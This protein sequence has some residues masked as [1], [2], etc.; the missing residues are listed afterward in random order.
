MSSLWEGEGLD[1]LKPE[2]LQG[3]LSKVQE[4]IADELSQQEQADS[5]ILPDSNQVVKQV[6]LIEEGTLFHPNFRKK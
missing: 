3:A 5:L 2:Y 4:S 6:F 1:N